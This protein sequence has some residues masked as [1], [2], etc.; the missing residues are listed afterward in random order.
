MLLL[1]LVHATSEIGLADSLHASTAPPNHPI[2]WP[3]LSAL[4]IQIQLAQAPPLP[5]TLSL[6]LFSVLPV[7][8]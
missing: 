2:L 5:D 1:G 7:L 3:G 8:P 4:A 6:P